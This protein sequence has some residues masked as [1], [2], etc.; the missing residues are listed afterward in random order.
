M[1]TPEGFGF[2]TPATRI[3]KEADR[4]KGFFRAEASTPVIDVIAAITEGTKD[5]SLVYDGDNLLGIFTETDYIKVCIC[6]FV[7]VCVFAVTRRIQGDNDDD[8]D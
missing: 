7:C 6:G 5:V 8:H 4:D 3:L 2:S 1:L